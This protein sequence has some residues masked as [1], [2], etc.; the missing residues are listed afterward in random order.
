MKRLASILLLVITTA[1]CDCSAPQQEAPP[2]LDDYEPVAAQDFHDQ[3]VDAA[4]TGYRE[5]DDELV[6]GGVFH[7]FFLSV[8]TSFEDELPLE[9]VDQSRSTYEAIDDALEER[10]PPVLPTSRCESFTELVAQFLGLQPQ[11]LLDHI[12]EGIVDYDEDAAGQ[13]I[14]RLSTAPAVCD[15]GRTVRGDEFNMQRYRAV[16][17]RHEDYLEDFYAPCT[18][19]FDGTRAEEDPCTHIYECAHGYCE[20][21][22]GADTGVCGPDRPTFWLVP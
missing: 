7:L 6:R 19:I 1:A 20:W 9:V 11:A 3:L 8:A 14:E 17:S 4:C 22:A 5:C 18:E 12:D 16:A 10:S 15:D 21:Y 13:C 2:A